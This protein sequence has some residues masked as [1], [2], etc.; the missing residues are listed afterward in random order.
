MKSKL[1][2]KRNRILSEHLE[3]T[4]AKGADCARDFLLLWASAYTGMGEI[5]VIYIL[6]GIRD[7]A[8]ANFPAL[9]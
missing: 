9:Y 6:F 7:Q 8:K 4:G 2:V 5:M 3:L 1:L